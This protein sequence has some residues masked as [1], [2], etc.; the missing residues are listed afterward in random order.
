MK[1]KSIRFTLFH[2]ENF[3]HVR[4]RSEAG[5]EEERTGAPKYIH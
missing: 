1:S 2:A 3:L 5:G 4:K